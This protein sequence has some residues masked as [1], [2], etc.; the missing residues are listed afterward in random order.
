MAII[1]NAPRSATC[2]AVDKCDLLSLNRADF[3][4][5]I[6]NY[7]DMALKIL[8]RMLTI[9]SQRFKASGAAVSE[10]VRWG[11]NARK[12][13]IT[14]EFTGLFNRRFLEETFR[15]SVSRALGEKKPLTFVMAD[16]DNFSK[17]NKE[18]GE[19]FGD[20]VILMAAKVF[21]ESFRETDILV[22]YGGDEFVFVFPDTDAGLSVKLCQNMA[23]TLRQVR[24]PAHPGVVITLSIGI[25]AVP[26]HADSPTVLKDAADKAVYTAKEKG[27][28][29]IAVAPACTAKP[30]AGVKTEIPTIAERNRIINN[31]TQ[32]ILSQNSF[33]LLGHKDPDADCIASFVAFALLIAKFQKEVTIFLPDPVIEQLDY[34]LEIC[35]YNFI[36]VIQSM[37]TD[38]PFNINTVVI[39]DTPKPEMLMTNI[40][41]ARILEN[42]KVKKIE[43][44]HHLDSD[45]RYAGDPGYRLVSNASS[46]CELI[47]YL[48]LKFANNPDIT[49]ADNEFFSRNFALAILT[50]IVGDSQMGKYLKTNKE[51]WYYRIF[52]EKFNGLLHQKTRKNGKNLRSMTDIFDVIQNFSQREKECFEKMIIHLKKSE[53]IHYILLGK[54]DSKELFNRF[55]EEFIINVSKSAADQLSEASGKMGMV[56]YY[57]DPALS[58]FIQFRLRRS[59]NFTTLD[60]R[61]VIADLGI[62]NGGGHP[63]AVGFRVNKNQVED[64]QQ[65]GN[66]LIAN[67]ETILAQ[68]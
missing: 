13:A 31:I 10:M 33:L 39:L 63:G 4:D 47:G 1:E 51:Q 6:H 24:F 56:S 15:I 42:P 57:D 14:D 5:I 7:P 19:A 52:S 36:T 55:G 16:M 40:S 30:K 9:I 66:G 20:E 50:G 64:I 17:L 37:Q 21:R 2:K 25:A 44:D 34:L 61:K 3:Y 68:A 38:I 12:K 8:Y 26:E 27:R 65:Y 43:I 45:S 28:N 46:T 59:S 22:R 32:E 29:R 60:L 58:D 49:I 67:I 41:I 48:S 62:T 11:E 54:K 53:S 35:R 23:D 18:Y